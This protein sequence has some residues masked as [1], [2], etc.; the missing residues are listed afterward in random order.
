MGYIHNSLIA[1]ETE[2]AIGVKASD[3]I[4][5]F[6]K[7]QCTKMTNGWAVPAWLFKKKTGFHAGWT[8][9]LTTHLRDLVRSL[10][11]LGKIKAM[12][13]AAEF[14]IELKE[15]TEN[16]IGWECVNIVANKRLIARISDENKMCDALGITWTDGWLMLNDFIQNMEKM[17]ARG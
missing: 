17:L 16:E 4:E 7:S 15:A 11:R 9:S 8:T 3:T 1:K 5:F 13:D 14:G 2:K 12:E 6:P 10:I